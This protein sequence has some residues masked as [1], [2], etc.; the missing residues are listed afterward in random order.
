MHLYVYTYL[1]V[2]P[3]RCLDPLR[4]D[5]LR[6]DRPRRSQHVQTRCRPPVLRYPRLRFL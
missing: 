4:Q 2:S 5:P 3:H 6:Q 1:S